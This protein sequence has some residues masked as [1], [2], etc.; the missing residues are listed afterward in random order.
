LNL[1]GTPVPECWGGQA[2]ERATCADLLGENFFWFVDGFTDADVLNPSDRTQQKLTA[3]L[4]VGQSKSLRVHAGSVATVSGSDC[5][6]KA[7]SIEWVLS[8]PLVARIE[9]GADPRQ[10]LLV[11]V[12]PGD[13]GI[14]A[15]LAFNDGSPPIGALPYVFANV[16]VVRV[17][18][19]P[20]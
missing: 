8:N 9:V 1:G 16:T 2:F 7:I 3:I 17:V 12:N 19:S 20:Q 13:T 14:A 5:S 6:G 10:A 4:A 18:P 11:A 15:H